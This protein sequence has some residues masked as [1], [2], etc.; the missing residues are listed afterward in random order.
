VHTETDTVCAALVCTVMLYR[1]LFAQKLQATMH[2]WQKH[3]SN[4]EQAGAVVWT[5]YLTILLQ[6]S[7]DVVT[8][9]LICVLYCCYEL[10]IKQHSCACGVALS[11]E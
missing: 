2:Q 1:S 3:N 9:P 6:H 11:G 5:R 4:V 8:N 10:F 7:S